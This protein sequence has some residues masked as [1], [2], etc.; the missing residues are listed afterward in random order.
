MIPGLEPLGSAPKYE[1]K[2]SGRGHGQ[3][4]RDGKSQVELARG[5]FYGPKNVN[6]IQPKTP[7]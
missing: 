4:N 7:R 1:A 3:K 6:K 5:L 2:K